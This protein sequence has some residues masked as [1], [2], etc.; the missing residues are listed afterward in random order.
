LDVSHGEGDPATGFADPNTSYAD[1]TA[2]VASGYVPSSQPE[3]LAYPVPASTAAGEH[4]SSQYLGPGPADLTTPRD[5]RMLLRWVPET[6]FTSPMWGLRPQDLF[7]G[8]SSLRTMQNAR[9]SGD[10]DDDSVEGS[11]GGSKKERRAGK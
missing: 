6:T 5:R 11:D 4:A 2:A 3:Q 8:Q 9:G 7:H 1:S 10:E